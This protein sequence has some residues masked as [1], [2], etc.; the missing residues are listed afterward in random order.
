MGLYLRQPR[1][2]T[3]SQLRISHS[4]QVRVSPQLNWSTLAIWDT[5]GSCQKL[6]QDMCGYFWLNMFNT[7][8]KNRLG[9]DWIPNWALD[10][11][12]L[13][14]LL[15]TAD[16]RIESANTSVGS[17][18]WLVFWLY[19]VVCYVVS[20]RDVKEFLLDLAG[21]THYW[22]PERKEYVIIPLL[23]KING[24]SK[25][26]TH[27]VFMCVS[28]FFSDWCNPCIEKINQ[29]KRS[30][31][32]REIDQLCWK[33]QVNYWIKWDIWYLNRFV[34][35]LLC[36]K[37]IFISNRRVYQRKDKEQLSVFQN[38]QENIRQPITREK[39]QWVIYRYS[40]YI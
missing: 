34:N 14:K 21:L 32:G 16:E 19:T 36:G 26:A 31:G 20:L 11:R 22:R 5:W 28:Y 15:E 33:I 38:F 6:G 23:G 25:D 27:V 2:H 35:W 10:T 1:H 24:E 17:H 18:M 7:D 3:I 37:H 8:L 9:Q 13:L 4:N 12:L 30:L 39:S 40:E 29:R